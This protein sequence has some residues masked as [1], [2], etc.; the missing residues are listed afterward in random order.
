MGSKKLLVFL[1]FSLFIIATCYANEKM[2]ISN[3]HLNEDSIIVEI[4]LE[5]VIVYD[6]MDVRINYCNIIKSILFEP[7]EII[8]T[9]TNTNI[10]IRLDIKNKILY[11]NEEAELIIKISGGFINGRIFIGN[12]ISRIEP[13]YIFPSNAYERVRIIILNQYYVYRM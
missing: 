9:K 7:E 10:T 8:Y 5:N 6:I 3:C 4:D 12:P 11:T 1:A 13:F 2:E